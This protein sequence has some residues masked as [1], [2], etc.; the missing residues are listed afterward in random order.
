M[1]SPGGMP[2]WQITLIAVCAALAAAA[3]AVL[4]DRAWTARKTVPA[5]PEPTL[6]PGRGADG[7]FAEFTNAIEE[8]VERVLRRFEDRYVGVFG[9]LDE[10]LR[11]TQPGAAHAR[12]LRNNF[13]QNLATLSYFFA[14][15][16]HGWLVPLREEGFFGSPPEPVIHEDE[17]TAE[18]PFWP[19]THFLVRVAPGQEAE[20]VATALGIPATGNSRVNSDLI[21]LALRVPADHSARLLPRVIAS[22]GGRFAVLVPVSSSP[23]RSPDRR[24]GPRSR[25]TAWARQNSARS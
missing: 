4:L 14:R 15:A 8:L 20:V 11:V 9:R 23:A 24:A 1:S 16:G 10:L 19:Q 18:L 25:R 6:T 7:A 2:G 5:P 22:V 21:E 3:L 12:R 17:G 13:P